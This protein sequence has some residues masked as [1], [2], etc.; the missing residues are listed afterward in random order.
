[1]TKNLDDVLYESHEIVCGERHE[2][3]TGNKKDR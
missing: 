3:E 1:M 2:R